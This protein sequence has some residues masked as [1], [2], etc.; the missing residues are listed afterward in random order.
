MRE[1]DGRVGPLGLKRVGSEGT[2]LALK[3]GGG[4][5]YECLMAGTWAGPGLA[6]LGQ[7][8]GGRGAREGGGEEGT[9]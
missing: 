8:E 7:T 9:V 5:H 1:T 4:V 6:G 2:Q 3:G